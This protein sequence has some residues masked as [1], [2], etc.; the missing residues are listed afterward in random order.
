MKEKFMKFMYGRYGVDQ[1]SRFLL[2]I[3]VILLI[4]STFMGN[5]LL[6][7]VSLGLMVYLYFRVFSRNVQKRYAENNKYLKYKNRVINFFK[8]FKRDLSI[9]KTHHIYRC[10]NC[11][12][13]IKIPRNKG[14]IEIRCPKCYTEFIKKS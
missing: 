5:G 10:P 12:Q 4:V 11:R 13:K 1:Y 6:Y 8:H 14:R 2:I 9:R 7:I 3:A